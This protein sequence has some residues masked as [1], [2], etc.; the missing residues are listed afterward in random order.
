MSQLEKISSPKDTQILNTA[1]EL[2]MRFGVK[3]VTIE[4]IC[5]TANVSK[6]T[7]YKYFKNKSDLALRIVEKLMDEGQGIFD[8]IIAGDLSFA[9]K[10]EQFVQMK[11]D[12]GKRMSK[13]FLVDFMGYS[14]AVHD[15]IL[16][17]SQENRQRLLNAFKTAQKQGE[18][19]KNLNLQFVEYMMNNITELAQDT[20]LLAL[21]PDTYQLTKQWLDFFLY[22]I[23]GGNKPDE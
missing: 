8:D 11:L 19:R 18:I 13:E 16:R 10:M 17:R 21:F 14:P 5:R 20:Q 22:G 6:M 2:F 7:F 23:M 15:L 1:Q 4:E 12:Y 9:R 3:R